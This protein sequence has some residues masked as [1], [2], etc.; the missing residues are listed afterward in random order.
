VSIERGVNTHL[1]RKARRKTAARRGGLASL[2]PAMTMEWTTSRR[3][4]QE[5]PRP[6]DSTNCPTTTRYRER[7]Y[8]K[9][10]GANLSSKGPQ[11]SQARSSR[12]SSRQS[13]KCVPAYNRI[14]KMEFE[15]TLARRGRFGRSRVKRQKQ[16]DQRR[17]IVEDLGEGQAKFT[18]ARRCVPQLSHQPVRCLLPEQLLAKQLAQPSSKLPRA[19]RSLCRD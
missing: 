8:S 6:S 15:I 18:L 7:E 10:G 13:L 16:I 12:Q 1:V 9:P 11:R 2:F 19:R 5:Q 17:L 3:R 14:K 4:M